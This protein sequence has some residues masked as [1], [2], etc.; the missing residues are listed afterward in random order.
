MEVEVV[1]AL[2]QVQRL[3]RVALAPGSSVAD[4]V[5]ASGLPREFPAIDPAAGPFGIFGEPC[6]PDRILRPGDRVEI[7]RPLEVDPKEARRLR[8]ARRR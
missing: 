8:A 4:A 7:Y 5:T 1:Y 3:V 2:P 6:P